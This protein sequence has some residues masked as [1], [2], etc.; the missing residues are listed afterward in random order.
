MLDQLLT[1][2]LRDR[3][4]LLASFVVDKVYIFE[5]GCRLG[6]ILYLAVDSA[7]LEV[8]DSF[9][10]PL[11]LPPERIP[12]D[13]KVDRSKAVEFDCVNTVNAS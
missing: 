8:I 3:Y 7:A 13:Y 1:I 10:V 11:L 9:D 4:L 5:C 12:H 6:F 2:I